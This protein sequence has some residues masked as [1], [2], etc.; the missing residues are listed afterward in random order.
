MLSFSLL[1]LFS[2]RLAPQLAMG[3]SGW[4]LVISKEF[5]KCNPSLNQPLGC[6][7][8]KFVLLMNLPT[9]NFSLYPAK[10]VLLFQAYSEP[11]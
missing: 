6:L 1:I 8:E 3:I 7:K 10:I 4:C 9:Q 11:W 2:L 5:L